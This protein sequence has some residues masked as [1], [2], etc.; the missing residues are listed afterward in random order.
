[1]PLPSLEI[2]QA[3]WNRL[4]LKS[5][6]AVLIISVLLECSFLLVTQLP[7]GEFIPS[8]IV[9]PTAIMAFIVVLAEIGVRYLPK[10]H[11]YVLITSATF[12]TV[13]ITAIHS[14]LEYLLFFLFFP[15]MISIFYFQYKKLLFA[16]FNT[17]I[18]LLFLHAFNS[19]IHQRVSYVGVLTMASILLVYSGIAF[20]VLARG[21]ELLKH[22][23]TSYES[24]QELLVRTILMDKLA[25][26]DAL[27]DTYNHMAYHEFT[28]HLV[29]QADN[30]RI[31]LYLAV[32]DIDNFKKVNDT[33]GHKAGDEVLRSVASIARS[34]AGIN[35][36]VARYGG[37]EFV[38]LF[39][40][41]SF[42]DAFDL[43][44]EIRQA[45]AATS[46]EAIH[47]LNVT[48]SIGLNAYSPGMGKEVLFQGADA[49]LY[50]AKH[51]GKNRTA[52]AA[53][54][55]NNSNFKA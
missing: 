19:D 47:G 42:Q 23:H 28:D 51:S 44:E 38:L 22:L 4:L 53:S 32:M 36:I 20:G 55:Y 50:D 10:H 40:E 24:N 5:Y 6:W 21:R 18:S 49:A 17:V 52:L 9:R 45:I 48:V 37:E 41:K 25:K 16:I 27:T 34:K 33:Y 29:V 12:L 43:A 3:R 8:Y 1:M 11:D 30:D 54:V 14:S 13:T 2:N 31:S 35:D 7:A 46:H 15:I 39:T 26:T